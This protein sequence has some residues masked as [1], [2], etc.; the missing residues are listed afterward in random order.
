MTN[1]INRG[2]SRLQEAILRYEYAYYAS[3]PQSEEAFSHSHR[4]RKKIRELC[5]GMRIVYRPPHLGIRKSLAVAFAAALIIATGILSVS[6]ARTAVEEWFV[7]IYES[8]TEIFSAQ[9]D[10]DKKPDSIETPYTPAVLPEGYRKV[11]EF[12]AQSERKL[13]FENG[14]GERIF[15]IQTP[16]SSKTTI[17]TENAEYE[18]RE[19]DGVSCFFTQKNGKICVYWNNDEYAFSLI[20][21][22]SVGVEQCSMILVSVRAEN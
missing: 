14:I 9:A 4:Y 22:E 17:D 7:H 18:M 21:P 11:D 5:R 10:V 1:D 2:Q 3:M 12:L 8:F 15:F 6:A 19:I 20:L 16:L 13:T